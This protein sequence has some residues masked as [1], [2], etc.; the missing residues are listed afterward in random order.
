MTNEQIREA[1][2][3]RIDQMKQS[4]S[5]NNF[6]LNVSAATLRKEIADL[7]HKCSH[8]DTENNFCLDSGCYCKYCGS[9]VE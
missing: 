6:E 8:K 9:K 5:A 1:I 7:Q 3:I 4:F 2:S